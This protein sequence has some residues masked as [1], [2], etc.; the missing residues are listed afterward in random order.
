[1]AGCVKFQN[2]YFSELAA[3]VAPGDTTIQVNQDGQLGTLLTGGDWVYLNLV[4][5]A[6]WANGT[7]PFT[8]YEIVKATA[9]SG[10]GPFTI[11]VVRG[12]D[13]TAATSFNNCDIC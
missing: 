10:S 13:N 9:V 5:A 8:T 3:P 1:M 2:F 7:I 6:S 12:Q 4:D 11:T